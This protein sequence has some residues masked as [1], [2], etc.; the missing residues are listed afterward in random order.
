MFIVRFFE[1]MQKFSILNFTFF[2]NMEK[3]TSYLWTLKKSQLIWG[4]LI[5]FMHIFFKWLFRRDS[6]VYIQ[7]LMIKKIK[8]QVLI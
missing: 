3:D 2:K 6:S 4:I 8:P 1:K 7:A 5:L